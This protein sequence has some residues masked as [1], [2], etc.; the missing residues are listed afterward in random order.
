MFP[1]PTGVNERQTDPTIPQDYGHQMYTQKEI[2]EL[3][4]Q[5]NRLQQEIQTLEDKIKRQKVHPINFTPPIVKLEINPKI[6]RFRPFVIKLTINTSYGIQYNSEDVLSAVS[7]AKIRNENDMMKNITSCWCSSNKQIIEVGV[8]NTSS[9]GPYKTNEGLVY[10]L[11]Q[12]RSHCTS[13]RDHHHGRLILV[14]DQLAG[15][16]PILSNGF[17]LCARVKGD[18]PD[19][20]IPYKKEDMMIPRPNLR[21]KHRVNLQFDSVD[22]LFTTVFVFASSLNTQQAS[23]MLNEVINFLKSTEGFISYMKSTNSGLFVLFCNYNSYNCGSQASVQLKSYLSN[24]IVNYLNQDLHLS[25]QMRLLAVS[26]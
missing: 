9:I 20:Y 17:E 8:S 15:L 19:D 24:Q 16:P 10:I 21:E 18:L 11:D 26:L 5:N 7:K 6:Y 23:E 25:G 4:S 22:L 13:S 12:C 2:E 14:V 1:I 3:S